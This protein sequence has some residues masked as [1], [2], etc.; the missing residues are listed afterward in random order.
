M[1]I[2]RSIRPP[3]RRPSPK[4]ILSREADQPCGL[5]Q[6]LL[7][8]VEGIIDLMEHTR[9]PD[10]L[11]EL[12]DERIVLSV[13]A[14][15]LIDANLDRVSVEYCSA[16]AALEDASCTIQEAIQGLESVKNAILQAAKAA[17]LVGKVAAMA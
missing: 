8:V 11:K 2:R 7:D 4:R 9:D 17:E 10:R 12:N 6:Q 5:G 16:T 13:E 14:R 15:R 3:R 1:S